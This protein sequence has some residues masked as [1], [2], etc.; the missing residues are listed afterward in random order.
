MQNLPRD[1]VE[2]KATPSSGLDCRKVGIGCACAA[3]SEPA[4]SG[5]STRRSG[6][7]HRLCHRQER[8]KA[9]IIDRTEDSNCAAGL[10]IPEE[11]KLD[12]IRFAAGTA[13]LHILDVLRLGKRHQLGVVLLAEPTQLIGENLTCLSFVHRRT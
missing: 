12:V 7:E 1:G 8:T 9:T 10:I 5:H 13:N 11:L 3:V 6:H 2:E 4:F